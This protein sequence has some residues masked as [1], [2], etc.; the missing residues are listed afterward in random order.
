MDA[1]LGAVEIITDRAEN[2]FHADRGP[3]VFDAKELDA[4]KPS[5][6]AGTVFPGQKKQHQPVLQPVA[7]MLR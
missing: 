7:S 1:V 6:L 2:F 3:S 5:L 4:V